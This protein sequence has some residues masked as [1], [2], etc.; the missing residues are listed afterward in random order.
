MPKKNN[1]KRNAYIPKWNYS[2]KIRFRDDPEYWESTNV[3]LGP[4]E[5]NSEVA[6][7]GKIMSSNLKNWTTGQ[8]ISAQRVIEEYRAKYVNENSDPETRAN[9]D[10]TKFKD[11]WSRFVFSKITMG[12]KPHK[13]IPYKV[14]DDRI[15]IFQSDYE[16]TRVCIGKIDP[17]KTCPK[18]K[19]AKAAGSFQ[20]R[21]QTS[22]ARS[23]K[24]KGDSEECDTLEKIYPA[25]FQK[26]LNHLVMVP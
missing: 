20:G 12:N 2:R 19:P 6:V 5:Y 1:N 7:D 8:I 22:L 11:V 16:N 17:I 10:R 26:T 3:T 23:N 14:I 9:I 18:C 24:E 21:D 15:K 4:D 25:K 13:Q